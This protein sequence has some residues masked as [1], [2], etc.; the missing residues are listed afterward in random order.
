MS[1]PTQI[2]LRW[3]ELYRKLLVSSRT[4]SPSWDSARLLIGAAGSLDVYAQGHLKEALRCSDVEL[5]PLRD[6]LGL[7][8]GSHR[9]LSADREE[10]YSDWLAWIL[11]GISHAA[12]ILPLFGRGDETAAEAFGQADHVEREGVSEYGRTDIEVRFGKQGLLLIETKVGLLSSDLLKTQLKRYER[13]A[14]RQRVER[15]LLVLLAPEEPEQNI[16]PFTFTDW[17]RLCC[18]LRQYA[19]RAKNA[20]LLHSAAILMFCGAAEQNLLGLSAAPRRFRAMAT[21]DYLRGWSLE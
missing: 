18:R 14:D 15:R 11:Q 3:H 6:P 12:E 8:L 7:P 4:E 9:W 17:R 20:D 2:L 5:S 19:N 10:S 16:A 1:Y 13:W 21:I